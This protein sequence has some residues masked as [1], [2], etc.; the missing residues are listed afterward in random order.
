MITSGRTKTM[1]LSPIARLRI[2]SPPV[3][4]VGVGYLVAYV[5]LD[6]ISFIEPYGP[7]GITTWNPSTGLS[8]TLGLL[9]GPRMIPLLFVGPLLSDLILNQS[10]VPW[11]VELSFVVVIGSGY[12]AALL[13]LLR[14]SL[15]FDPALSSMRDLILLML[16]AL[17]STAF[18]AS[19]YVGVTILAGL[20]PPNEFAAAAFRYWVGDIIGIMVVTPV[21]LIL[22]TRN[23][24]LRIS[25]ETILQF[26]A[27]IGALVVLFGYAQEQRFQLFYIL[28]LPIIWMAVRT[29]SEGVTL[30]ILV[31]QLGI[32]AGVTIFPVFGHDVLAFQVLML[33]LTTTGLIAGELVTERRRT[34]FQLRLHR[35]SLARVAQLGGMGELTVAIAHEL[36]QPLMAARTY[37]RLVEDAVSSGDEDRG[38]VA[39]TAKKA[40]AQVERAAEVLRSLRALIRLDSSNRAAYSIERIIKETVALCQP[41]LDRIHA[42]ARAVIA[43]GLPPVKV[44]ILQIEQVLLNL[45]HNSVDAIDEI[46]TANRSIV[47]EAS[48]ASTDFIEV[49]VSDNGPGFPP[50]LLSDSFLPFF[51]TKA[52]GLGF[53]LSLCKSIVEAHGGRLWLDRNTQGGGVHF[54]IPAAEISHDD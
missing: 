5:L 54:T 43:N 8:L 37:T 7:V 14:P 6:W 9:F 51:S 38:M 30:G 47:I 34:E 17:L 2:V 27:I 16:V 33:I 18:V 42:S 19:S 12:S 28:F 10:P 29:G 44:D 31:T 3:V 22:L 48:A 49:R 20:L 40:V 36:N 41:D 11:S 39:E 45:L 25:I 1:Q 4:I 15:Q 50:D 23:H 13:F 53:G 32:I 46:E 21:V 24:V 52:E 26:V 35:D